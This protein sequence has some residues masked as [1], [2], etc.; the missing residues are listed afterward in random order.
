M[1]LLILVQT[2]G[3]FHTIV[4]SFL[5]VYLFVCLLFYPDNDFDYCLVQLAVVC[6]RY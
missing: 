5:F 6:V 1:K 3:E 4:F 2:F